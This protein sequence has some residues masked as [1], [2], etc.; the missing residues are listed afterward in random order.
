M[1]CNHCRFSLTNVLSEAEDDWQ[2]HRGRITVDLLKELLNSAAAVT[3]HN[4][5]VCVCGPVQFTSIALR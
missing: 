4:T 1:K 2:G 5:L 3:D